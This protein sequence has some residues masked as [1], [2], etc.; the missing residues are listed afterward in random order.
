L[1]KQQLRCSNS[2]SVV[3][4]EEVTSQQRRRTE[5]CWIRSL[6]SSPTLPPLNRVQ[7]SRNEGNIVLATCHGW[8]VGAGVGMVVTECT[9]AMDC[10]GR[11]IGICVLIIGVVAVV[12]CDFLICH[13]AIA[14]WTTHL[15]SLWEVC[16]DQT[17]K[18]EGNKKV[19]ANDSCQT[20][21]EDHMSDQETNWLVRR[22]N[23]R[24]QSRVWPKD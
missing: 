18:P 3:A 15:P 20:N 13:S 17:F 21:A 5:S 8:H 19:W 1:F 10:H 9:K 2:S 22:S 11:W 14:V 16:Y 12:R 6:L 4:Y 24:T 7:N 23:G